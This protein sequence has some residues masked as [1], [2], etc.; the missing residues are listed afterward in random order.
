MSL[1]HPSLRLLSAQ[2]PITPSSISGVSQQFNNQRLPMS[3][4]VARRAFSKDP[5]LQATGRLRESG[6]AANPLCTASLQS[7]TRMT[8][9]ALMLGCQEMSDDGHNALAGINQVNLNS[10]EFSRRTHHTLLSVT[11]H[12]SKNGSSFHPSTN[13]LCLLER[14]K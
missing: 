11:Y 9:T 4:Q 3:M 10:N 12:N 5:T 13:R 7:T 6:S 14:L 8:I 2:L 1:T